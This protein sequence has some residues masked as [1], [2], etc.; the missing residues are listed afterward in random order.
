MTFRRVAAALLLALVALGS[1]ALPASAHTEL[2]SS[3]PAKG[4][5]LPAPPQQVELT[6]TESVTAPADAITVTGPNGAKWTVG[7]ATVAGPVV[8]A[9]V[10]ATG[11]AGTY[12]ITWKVVS[13]D[14]DP[15]TGTIDFT[16]SAPTTTTVPTTTTTATAA[17]TSSA[18]P[19]AQSEN[20]NGGVP[21]WVWILAGVL[22][23]VGIGTAIALRRKG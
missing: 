15:V 18:A 16:L 10:Q 11:P 20:D 12:T 8:T 23:L 22:V 7:Q 6:F 21:A 4:A 1:T 14:G 9:P 19:A 2:K 17:A 13:D 5:A 3:N